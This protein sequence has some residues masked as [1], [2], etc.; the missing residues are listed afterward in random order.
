MQN[1]KNA[2]RR[3]G[4]IPAHALVDAPMATRKS[5]LLDPEIYRRLHLAREYMDDCY[6]LP[7]QLEQVARR[8]YFSPYHFLRL[9]QTAFH[10]TPHQYLIARRIEKAKQLLKASELSV[11][12]VCFEVGFQSLGSFSSL[13]Y[14]IVGQSPS[15]Y[16][17]EHTWRIS[18]PALFST[19]PIPACFLA[20]FGPRPAPAH[21][22]QFSRSEV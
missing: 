20:M 8:A 22:S 6:Q 2:F 9:F 7:L 15:H 16:R 3:A 14:K 18:F 10:R 19:T 11:T 13:F 17:A 1:N 21:K 12:A 4:K 5:P